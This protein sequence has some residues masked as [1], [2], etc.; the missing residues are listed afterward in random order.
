[1]KEIYVN[2]K[3]FDVPKEMGGICPSENPVE[4]IC[5][6]MQS[7]IQNGLGKIQDVAV[8]YFLPEAL[9]VP[10]LDIL[11]RYNKEEIGNFSI[12]CQGVFREDVI[13][14][15]NFGAFTA[16]RPAA[17]MKALGCSWTMIGHSEERKDKLGILAAYDEKIKNDLEASEQAELTV[18]AILNQ[19][20][21]AALDR[22][23]NVLFCVGET[24]EQKASDV[25]GE[26]EP[27]VKKVL[28]SQLVHGLKGIMEK[29]GDCKIAIGYEP[30]WAIGPGKIPP[31]R[32]YVSFVSS[33][34]KEVCKAEFGVEL[35]VVYGGGLKEENA[36]EM[37]AV[38]TLDG[39]LVALTK[40][41]QPIAFDVNSLKNIIGA[42]VK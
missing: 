34:I 14:G 11:S 17:A 8:T 4:W 41:T 30:I 21:C 22:K 25:P 31:N 24:A 29:G 36:S 12:G 26:Y 6:T 33:Y 9:F 7:T 27:R 2:L 39:G 20:V 38:K 1:V 5:D 3:R 35:S 28:Y 16:N 23:M 18:S 37:A 42:Y 19:E 32:D 40:F 13:S 15:K 10:A